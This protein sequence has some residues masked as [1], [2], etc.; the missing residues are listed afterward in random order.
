[1]S[2]LRRRE[3]TRES[4]APAGRGDVGPVRRLIIF[5]APTLSALSIWVSPAP[6]AASQPYAYRLMALG[7]FVPAIIYAFRVKLRSH[8]FTLLLS[9]TALL[10]LWGWVGLQW[11]ANPTLGARQ[12]IAATTGA[13][14]AV[15]FFVF[16]RNGG[17]ATARRGMLLALTAMCVMGQIEHRTGIAWDQRAGRVW[18]HGEA[19]AGP[20]IN[21]NNFAAFLVLFMAPTIVVARGSTQR[22]NRTLA[23]GILIVAAYTATL[24]QSR[25][26]WIVGSIVVA[27]GFLWPI[28]SAKRNPLIGLAIVTTGVALLATGRFQ[29]L[30]PSALSAFTSEDGQSDQYRLGLSKEAAQ[31]FLKSRGVGIGPGGFYEQLRRD[32][33][34]AAGYITDAHNSFLQ[35]AAE[36]GAL[37]SVPLFLLLGWLLWG[38]ISVATAAPGFGDLISRLRLELVLMIVGISAA[39]VSASSLVAD[40][41]WWLCWGYA[42]V[43]AAELARVGEVTGHVELPTVHAARE[44]RA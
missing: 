9:L 25:T 28:R 10:A 32:A 12:V 29:S 13:A 6:G 2:Q 22:W 43:V 44:A 38:A 11:S 30:F 31:Y 5:S 1:M 20:F 24:T 19:I 18:I 17:L 14:G 3:R 7:L 21:P 27:I 40:S 26:A 15:M 16:C 36:Y 37:V 4:H 41:T 23:M 35:L 8:G 42:A 33:G 34:G 39:S